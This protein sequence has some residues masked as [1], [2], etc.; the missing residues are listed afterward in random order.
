MPYIERW[1][2]DQMREYDSPPKTCGELNY[3]LSQEIQRYLERGE[4]GYQRFNDVIGVLEC[5][6]LELFR[7]KVAPYEDVK[8]KQNGDVW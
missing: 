6:K 8:I 4:P 2:R 3:A 7:R 1:R 5:L